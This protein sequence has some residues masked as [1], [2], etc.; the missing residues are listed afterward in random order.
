MKPFIPAVIIVA[1]SG[2]VY[3]QNAPSADNPAL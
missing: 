3:G 2:F 1:I